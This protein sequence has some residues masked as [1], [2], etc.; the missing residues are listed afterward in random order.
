MVLCRECGL[1]LGPDRRRW[2]CAKCKA[3]VDERRDEARREAKKR[4]V[5]AKRSERYLDRRCAKCGE[6]LPLAAHGCTRFCDD[7]RV[8]RYIHPVDPKTKRRRQQC[9]DCGEFERMTRRSHLC[10][11]CRL[12][13]QLE[14]Q[15]RAHAAQ[16]LQKEAAVAA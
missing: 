6:M 4:R 11:R 2:Y 9:S 14:A 13:R 8:D 12:R 10:R 5:A 16:R 7:C 1:E 3:K 15:H